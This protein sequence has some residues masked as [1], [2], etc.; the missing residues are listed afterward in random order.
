MGEIAQLV[1]VIG[2]LGVFFL[3]SRPNIGL[4]LI[5]APVFYIAIISMLLLFTAETEGKHDE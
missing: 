5:S 1:V 4:G 3:P 2:V